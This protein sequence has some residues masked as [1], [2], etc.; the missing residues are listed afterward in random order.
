MIDTDL[1]RIAELEAESARV[2]ARL[3]DLDHRIKND[4]QLVNSILVLQ[5]RRTPE[6]REREV[7][8]GMIDRM[9]AVSA[10]HRRLD[11]L[12]DPRRFDASLLVREVVEE[13]AA[14]ARRAG[15]QVELDLAAV[16]A[17][18][19]QAA[20]LAL[21]V[22]E[23]VRNSVRHAFP[24]RPGVLNVAFGP[25]EGAIRLCVRDDGVGLAPGQLPP[26]GFGAT[27]VALLVQQLRGEVE[28]GPA[29]PGVAAVVRFPPSA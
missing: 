27:L 6:G 9:G 2:L 13:A 21:I 4:L 15:V 1:D 5:L 22:G 8:R 26:N 7:L 19:R 17:P 14:G 18:T 29:H 25:A 11:A 12:E 10:V 20:P 16:K 28:I 24:E 3:R 23:L